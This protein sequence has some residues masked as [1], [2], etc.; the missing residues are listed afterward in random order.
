MT[1]VNKS[2]KTVGSIARFMPKKSEL[3]NLYYLSVMLRMLHRIK[4][5]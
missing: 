3:Q 2:S 1:L 5:V 4:A